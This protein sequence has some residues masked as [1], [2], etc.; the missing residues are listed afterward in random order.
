[1]SNTN[2]NTNKAKK[3][4]FDY[5]K[6]GMSQAEFKKVSFDL[7][8]RYLRVL[9]GTDKIPYFVRNTKETFY[10]FGIEITDLNVITVLIGKLSNYRKNK[11]TGEL[12]NVQS[13]VVFK[14]ML[15][16]EFEKYA[17]AKVTHKAKAPVEKSKKEKKELHGKELENT[18]LENGITVTK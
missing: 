12:E 15:K 8:I 2:T 9:D 6:F 17:N 7:F 16:G 10:R 4:P 1:M 11:E 14:R 5:S 3:A 13:F 18:L